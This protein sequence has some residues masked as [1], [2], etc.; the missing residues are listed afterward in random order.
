MPDIPSSAP[1]RSSC[2]PG[3]ETSAML[4]IKTVE[5]LKSMKPEV[6][7]SQQFTSGS[8]RTG[9]IGLYSHWFAEVLR[10]KNDRPLAPPLYSKNA[11][12]ARARRRRRSTA[13]RA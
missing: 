13:R 10:S 3:T 1:L 2:R 8:G 5:Q 4:K 12:R 7:A 6:E 11:A 9:P